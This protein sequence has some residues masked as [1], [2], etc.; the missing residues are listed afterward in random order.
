M[1][2]T[3]SND[4]DFWERLWSRPVRERAG[5]VA[6]RRPNAH[7][8]AEVGGLRRDLQAPG[9]GG[10]RRDVGLCRTPRTV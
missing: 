7:L 2:A 8:T 1:V 10:G 9:R 3:P 5:G 4:Q 6:G